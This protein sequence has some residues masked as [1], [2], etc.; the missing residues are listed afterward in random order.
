MPNDFILIQIKKLFNKALKE[1]I[2]SVYNPQF[3]LRYAV[4]SPFSSGKHEL[5]LDLKILQMSKR[6]LRSK[7]LL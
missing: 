1:A 4:Y 6:S 7:V 2:Q 5:L 3:S